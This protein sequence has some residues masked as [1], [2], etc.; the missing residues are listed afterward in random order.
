MTSNIQLNTQSWLEKYRPTTFTE[1]YIEKTHLDIVKKWINDFCNNDV[2]NSYPFLILHGT[3][4]I[5]KTTLAYLIFKHF[6][7][8]I[9]ECNASDSRTKKSIRDMIGQISKVSVCMDDNNTFKKTAIIMDEIDGLIGGE[10]NSVQELIDIVTKDKDS[11]LLTHICPVI[12]TTNSIKDKKL[13]P[14]LKQ[15]VVLNITK[16]T[17]DNCLKLIDRICKHE[18]IKISKIIKND[19]INNAYGDYRQII[20]LLYSHYISMKIID[21]KNI[22]TTKSKSL[23]CN[24]NPNPTSDCSY[25]N[26][27]NSKEHFD[28]IK[29]ITH[30]C[31]TPLEKIHYFLINKIHNE[32]ICHM[33]SDDSNLYYMN[34]YI[35]IIPI[36]D[37]LYSNPVIQSNNNKLSYYELLS[38]LY[39][40]MK[41]ADLLNN[42]IFLDKEWDLLDYFDYIGLASPLQ[43]LH[44][45][46]LNYTPQPQPQLETQ[47]TYYLIKEFSLV[48][49]TQY[50]FMRQEQSMIRKKLHIDYIITHNIDITNIY[51]N[52]KRFKYQNA[53]AIQISNSR[54]KKKKSNASVYENK[55]KIDRIY[56]KI[57][58]K[59]DELLS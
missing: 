57:I 1:Y 44:N 28:T 54:S 39:K 50:N 17:N 22:K 5:G 11:N 48:H 51:F 58:E 35:N 7:Y 30:H 23:L 10:V 43:I 21:T 29:Q 19:I 56:A 59:I 24:P 33:C 40:L 41:N 36:V 20:M 32:D 55:Y 26:Y 27:N 42:A 45:I 34:L 38:K 52:M 46:N 6:D 13:Q 14:L 49:H 25:D 3:A 16:P 37:A 53:E 31:E 47:S 12:C 2:M 9:I 15:A 4:G 18:H 8:E